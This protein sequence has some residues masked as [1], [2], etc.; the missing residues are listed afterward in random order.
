M[1]KAGVAIQ[2]PKIT[3]EGFRIVIFGL[4]IVLL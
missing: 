2:K 3:T 4:R 1:Q